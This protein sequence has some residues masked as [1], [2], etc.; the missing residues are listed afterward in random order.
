MAKTA[1]DIARNALLGASFGKPHLVDLRNRTGKRVRARVTPC[2]GTAAWK[3]DASVGSGRHEV[4]LDPAFADTIDTH[5]YRG[6]GGKHTQKSQ[7]EYGAAMVRHEKWHG[8]I[9]DRDLA[10]VAAHCDKVGVP[11]G[12][13]NIGEDLR[14]EAAARAAETAP[15]GWLTW[16]NVRG[17]TGTRKWDVTEPLRWLALATQVETK[18]SV[19][20]FLWAGSPTVTRV[21]GGVPESAPRKTANILDEFCDEIIAAPSTIAVVDILADLFATFP[22]AK[23]DP[24]GIGGITPRVA[25]TGYSPERGGDTEA[26]HRENSDV[27]KALDSLDPVTRAAFERFAVSPSLYDAKRIDFAGVKGIA[28][29]LQTLLG[30]LD[31]PPTR[32]AQSGSRIHVP[33]VARG[34]AGSFRTTGKSGGKRRVV[35][36]CDQSGS[37]NSQ[38]RNHG[39]AFAAAMLTLAQRGIIDAKVILTGG[40]RYCELPAN[41]P[42]RLLSI[43][44][45]N[46]GCESVAE[47]MDAN[48]AAIRAAETT[49]VYT[50]G[51]LTDGDVVKSEW[52]AGGVDV[53]GCAV[54]DCSGFSAQSM[55]TKLTEHFD[56]GIVGATGSA[57]AAALVQ[58][59]GR[60]PKR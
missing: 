39:A 27:E 12:A 19:F 37:M 29:R 21:R 40:R 55:Q 24:K 14:I 52:R 34:E 13:L 3:F 47:T 23:R 48:R 1:L 2:G 60:R 56:R 28:D 9:T 22:T 32:V 49:I 4:A 53:V 16:N 10:A 46:E 42:V 8:L 36:I 31:A 51:C 33:N 35:L 57:M 20:G 44:S 15:F 6:R 18:A 54:T 11:F 26:T 30:K 41:F 17:E 43:T 58:Y 59:I 25:G 7:C 50:D 45:C 5:G 38:W